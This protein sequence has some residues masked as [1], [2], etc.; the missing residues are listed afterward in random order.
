MGMVKDD[1]YQE[2]FSTLPSLAFFY[3]RNSKGKLP[4]SSIAAKDD[5]VT[6]FWLQENRSPLV[7][8]QKRFFQ[9]VKKG[10]VH[11]LQGRSRDTDTENRLVHTGGERVAWIESVM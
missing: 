1:F 3:C 2:L 6:L 7:R 10:Q 11:Y 9:S 4:F 8:L 5:H